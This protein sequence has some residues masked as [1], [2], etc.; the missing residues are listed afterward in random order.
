[1]EK[2]YLRLT[3]SPDPQKVRPLAVLQES[4]KLVKKKWVQDHDYN[5]AL[6]QL[7][8]IRQDVT[9]QHL[10]GKFVVDVYETH[11]RIAIEQQDYFQ[12][13]ACFAQLEVLYEAGKYPNEYEFAAY[14]VLYSMIQKNI[15]DE[16]FVQELQTNR[17][18]GRDPCCMHALQIRHLVIDGNY[19][20]YFK[21]SLQS[22]RL[23]GYLTDAIASILR[24]EA[25]RRIYSAYRPSLAVSVLADM[26]GFPSLSHCHRLLE[27]YGVVMVV[28]GIV[29][30]KKSYEMLQMFLQHQMEKEQAPQLGLEGPEPEDVEDVEDFDDALQ[31]KAFW[32]KMSQ[33]VP[34]D[35]K[36][37]RISKTKKRK[38]GSNYNNI[39]KGALKAK[40]KEA[41]HA[42]IVI[43]DSD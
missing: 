24:V 9:V 39:T 18:A 25:L 30:T 3:S 20:K 41:K 7:K 23:C 32:H 22:P 6:S 35:E 14:R 33:G 12:L 19:V 31:D 40:S 38:N 34:T 36:R 29:D 5:S 37:K 16:S 10:T 4:L 2:E 8:S 15:S 1:M 13:S 26:L 28:S 27:E 11:A 21:I 17:A 42:V 43:S